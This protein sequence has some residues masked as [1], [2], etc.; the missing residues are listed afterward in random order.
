MKPATEYKNQNV[1][2]KV[3][4]FVVTG[5]MIV[6]LISIMYLAIVS[7]LLFYMGNEWCDLLYKNMTV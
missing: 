6:F 5:K 7:V 2:K 1:R 4:R 3:K